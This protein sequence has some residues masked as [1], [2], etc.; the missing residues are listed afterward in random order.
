MKKAQNDRT[1]KQEKRRLRVFLPIVFLLTAVASILSLITIKDD[2]PFILQIYP[3]GAGVLAF[4]AFLGTIHNELEIRNLTHL[5]AL[6]IILMGGV[7]FG[8]WGIFIDW[9]TPDFAVFKE[10]G[11]FIHYFAGQSAYEVF[12]FAG[13]GLIIDIFLIF[14]KSEAP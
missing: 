9:T 11:Q 12:W 10:N 6:F 2:A 14:G 13:T 3:V 4:V 5:L 1:N 7:I 8:M